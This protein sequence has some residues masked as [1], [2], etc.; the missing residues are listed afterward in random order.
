MCILALWAALASLQLLDPVLR[1]VGQVLGALAHLVPLVA[2]EDGLRLLQNPCGRALTPLHAL[3]R[4][5]GLLA[6]DHGWLSRLRLLRGVVVLQ[7]IVHV[8]LG[9]GARKLAGAL[10]VGVNASSALVLALPAVD[11]LG[12]VG[13]EDFRIASRRPQGGGVLRILAL[14]APLEVDLARR[15]LR[16]HVPLPDFSHSFSAVEAA[17]HADCQVVIVHDLI[18]F[19]MLQLPIIGIV[20]GLRA[21]IPVDFH[22][23]PVLIFIIVERASA[24][25]VLL[26]TAHDHPGVCVDKS[27]A[28]CH[29]VEVLR[30]VSCMALLYVDHLIGTY[31]RLLNGCL[32]LLG[33]VLRSLWLGNV[34]LL[35][36]DV[37]LQ[38]VLL[39][40]LRVLGVLG[41]VRSVWSMATLRRVRTL[42]HNLAALGLAALLTLLDLNRLRVGQVALAR[43]LMQIQ[44]RLRRR[45]F[46]TLRGVFL[47]IHK[48]LELLLIQGLLLLL[49]FDGF[50][51]GILVG[52]HLLVQRLRRILGVLRI[53]FPLLPHYLQ[54]PVH[55]SELK[56]S[57]GVRADVPVLVDGRPQYYSLVEKIGDLLVFHY[58]I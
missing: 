27:L 41:G 10:N 31:N 19:R 13:G 36:E 44:I 57:T 1:R 25:L 32:S 24:L 21:N 35:L 45:L 2:L 46:C 33:L 43:K 18:S 30:D 17:T 12:L 55:V 51:N 53:E 23:V 48:I 54:S 52:E 34:D 8:Q 20:K 22:Y 7:K 58:G 56:M 49:L 28:S 4:G 37:L 29:P 5:G 11:K 42:H 40:F 14:L 6:V 15:N 47:V 39:F 9:L 50:L 38:R 16:C 3:I 26:R